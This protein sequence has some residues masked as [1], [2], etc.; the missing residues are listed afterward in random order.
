MLPIMRDSGVTYVHKEPRKYATAHL[1]M[2]RYRIGIS[3]IRHRVGGA[4]G[5]VETGMVLSVSESETES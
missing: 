3:G 4:G 5:G 2:L 1:R